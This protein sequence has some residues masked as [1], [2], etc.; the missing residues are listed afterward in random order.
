MMKVV[1]IMIILIYL[2]DFV[3]RVC[4]V[5]DKLIDLFDEDD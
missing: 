3:G 2:E 1:L 4:G 5:A